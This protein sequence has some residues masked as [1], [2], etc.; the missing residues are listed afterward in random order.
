MKL[1]LRRW[2]QLKIRE[3]RLELTGKHRPEWRWTF[4]KVGQSVRRELK[5]LGR[6]KSLDAYRCSLTGYP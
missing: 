3:I 2:P 6:C 1:P 4:G 5:K